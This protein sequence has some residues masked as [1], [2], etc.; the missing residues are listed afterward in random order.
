MK[1]TPFRYIWLCLVSV[2]LSS[3]EI[4]NPEEPIPSYLDIQPFTLNTD[5]TSQGTSDSK[6]TEAW[7]FVN[8]EFLGAYSLPAR[9]P[10]LSTGD[11]EIR[12]EAGIKE[13]GIA[14]RPDIYVFYEPYELNLNLEPYE[15]YT[16]EPV[17]QYIPEA[18]FGFIE[19]FESNRPRIFTQ[20]LSGD[21]GIQLT[22][23]DVFQGEFSGKLMLRRDDELVVEVSSF[24][25]FSGLLEAGV[26]I[27]LEL[28]YKSEAPV[29]WGIVGDSGTVSGLERYYDAGFVPKDSWNKIYFSLAATINDSQLDSYQISLRAFL[30]DDSPDSTAVYLDNIKL[31]HF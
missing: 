6:I 9:V 30:N 8:G 4:I 3:C 12:V 10:V 7:V 16:I 31:V 29:L 11:T 17:T 21:E 2:F 25:E 1:T 22:Q 14:S 5:I 28:N 18:K 13:N 20:V 24:Q 23:E 15:S 27:Y 26:F 19:D